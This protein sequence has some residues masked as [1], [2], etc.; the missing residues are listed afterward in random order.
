MANHGLDY[1]EARLFI[2]V[3]M[4]SSGS[5]QTDIGPFQRTHTLVFRMAVSA[6]VIASGLRRN[7][8]RRMTSSYSA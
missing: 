4:S 6:A 8:G 5:G 1:R 7:L 2:Y 3:N